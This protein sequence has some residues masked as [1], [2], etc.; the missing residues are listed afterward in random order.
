MII[1]LYVLAGIGILFVL[2]VIGAVVLIPAMLREIGNAFANIDGPPN[3]SKRQIR[4]MN[5]GN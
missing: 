5:R 3:L 4:K 1:A 2:I